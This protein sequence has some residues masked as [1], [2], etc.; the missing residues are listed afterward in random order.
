M[1]AQTVK[2]KSRVTIHYELAKV[3]EL[4]AA[5]PTAK[6]RKIAI[7]VV[8]KSP[9]FQLRLSAPANSS[10][11]AAQEAEA[12]LKKIGCICCYASVDDFKFLCRN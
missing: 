2:G 3:C 11:A 7:Q 6:L 9:M 1:T 5:M 10:P 8:T 4:H 12:E